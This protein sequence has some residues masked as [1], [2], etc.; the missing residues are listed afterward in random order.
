MSKTMR[1]AFLGGSCGNHPLTSSGPTGL[2]IGPK[3]PQTR[4]DMTEMT[5]KRSREV[6]IDEGR[7]LQ[8]VLVEMKRP[9]QQKPRLAVEKGGK[10]LENHS[11]TDETP[12]AAPPPSQVPETTR[13]MSSGGFHPLPL[14]SARLTCFD[15][16]SHVENHPGPSQTPSDL[17]RVV[18]RG[19]KP[20]P[21]CSTHLDV[22]LRIKNPA[23]MSWTTSPL[24]K[25]KK[26]WFVSDGGNLHHHIPLSTISTQQ[27]TRL[28]VLDTP[29][30]VLATPC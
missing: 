10:W 28:C 12:Q 24:P 4:S 29:Q 23:G 25:T 22:Y 7:C 26:T 13:F 30:A 8:G 19:Y 3:S 1:F 17:D 11:P 20:I 16:Y 15:V 27:D 2:D 6:E 5:T 21:M 18:E 14:T 9:G